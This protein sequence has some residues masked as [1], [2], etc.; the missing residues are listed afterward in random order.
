MHPSDDPCGSQQPKL[1]SSCCCCCWWWFVRVC[2]KSD[3]SRTL[4]QLTS[5]KGLC[6]GMDGRIRH[7]QVGNQKQARCFKQVKTGHQANHTTHQNVSLPIS[8]FPLQCCQLDPCRDAEDGCRVQGICLVWWCLEGTNIT[9]KLSENVAVLLTRQ[10]LGV[11][12]QCNTDKQASLLY[13]HVW[14]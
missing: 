4:M 8:I 14:S 7:P 2:V 3:R 11:L 13:H 5:T 9:K 1:S 12:C 10:V 6:W